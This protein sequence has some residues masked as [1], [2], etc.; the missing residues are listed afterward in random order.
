MGLGL[1]GKEVVFMSSVLVAGN[2]LFEVVLV[3][4]REF[5]GVV[6]CCVVFAACSSLSSVPSF[7]TSSSSSESCASVLV[8]S[9][10]SCMFS[11]WVVG[12]DCWGKFVGWIV[13][14]EDCGFVMEEGEAEGEVATE[15]VVA[16]WVSL[17]ELFICFRVW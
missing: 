14:V 2:G 4:V 13:R 7:S 1:C 3:L 9:S 16:C 6:L 11:S 8:S 10:V 17:G 5:V 15:A 12:G